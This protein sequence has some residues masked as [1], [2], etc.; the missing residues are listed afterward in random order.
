MS[1]A[2]ESIF[3][4]HSA[5]SI[6]DYFTVVAACDISDL[7]HGLVWHN[8]W[9]PCVVKGVYRHDQEYPLPSVA[10]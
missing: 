9:P 10:P 2:F 1:V 4:L 7:K 5:A 3:Y 6:K 8:K